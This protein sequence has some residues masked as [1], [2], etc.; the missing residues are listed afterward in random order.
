MAWTKEQNDAIYT[1]GSNIVVSAGAGSGKTAV[2]SERM[3]DFALKG[4]DITEALVLTFTSAAAS[5]MKERIRKKLIDNQLLHQAD[6]ID[7]AYITTFDAYSL[8]LVKKYAYKLGLSKDIKIMDSTLEEITRSK[9]VRGLFTELYE[10]H[11][12]AFFALLTKYTNQDDKDLFTII[13]KISAK[14]DLI[15]DLDSFIENYE[16]TY[17]ND[18]HLNN[19]VAQYI[20]IAKNAL[21]SFL[22]ELEVLIEYAGADDASNAL[23]EGCQTILSD[24]R[25]SNSYEDIYQIINMM[26]LPRISTKASPLVKEI[27]KI[28]CLAPLIFLLLYLNF[29][30]L[31]ILKCSHYY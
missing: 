2:L 25:G 7:S 3:L 27:K 28:V 9:I 6:L 8:A 18:D 10:G 30:F 19:T 5:E 4:N 1:R 24:L 29:C 15:I 20:A 13:N 21:N 16:Y 17:F 31:Y 14:L 26:S 11:D 22:Q 12:E 23:Y